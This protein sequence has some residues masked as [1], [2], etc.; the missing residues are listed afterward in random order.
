MIV[1]EFYKGQGLGNQL[2]SYI[3]TR[4]I[5]EKKG[6]KYGIMHPENFKGS[7]FLTLDFGEI[8]IGGYGPDGG[9]P[10]S[11]PNDI[12][13]YYREKK[14]LLWNIDI[15]TCD[16][17][18]LS[19]HDN[20]K[21]DGDFQSEKYIEDYRDFVITCI[22]FDKAK[23]ILDYSAEDVCILNIR[24]GEYKT[25]RDLLL[26]KSYWINS[27]LKM[28]EINSLM[29]FFVVTDDVEYAKNLLP[30]IE[31][32][33]RGISADYSIIKNAQNLISFRIN[34]KISFITII[35]LNT[36]ASCKT[37]TIITY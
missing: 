27:M 5:A 4:V 13:Y 35:I 9:P 7:E 20:T 14:E 24:G 26:P 18:L 12:L 8:V 34:S 21:I 23:E 31:I 2:W 36:I 19:I 15:S 32:L 29:K 28:K 6:Y 25:V 17:N 16:K 22:K 11:L 37:T 3:T 30:G 1:T 10:Y 33:H